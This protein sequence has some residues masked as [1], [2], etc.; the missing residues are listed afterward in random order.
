MRL[1]PSPAGP[2]GLTFNLSDETCT[3]STFA[4]LDHASRL[5]LT[6]PVTSLPDFIFE[7]S[8]KSEAETATRIT[9]FFQRRSVTSA[10]PESNT[11]LANNDKLAAATSKTR[12]IC[13]TRNIRNELLIGAEI[14]DIFTPDVLKIGEGDDQQKR[15]DRDRRKHIQDRDLLKID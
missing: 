13:R 6:A 3:N 7:L 14:L 15:D 12:R 2:E 9:P 4:I 5:R 8:R 11:E 10:S 1:T